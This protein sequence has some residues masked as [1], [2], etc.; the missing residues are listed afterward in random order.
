MTRMRWPLIVTL[1]LLVALTLSAIAAVVVKGLLSFVLTDASIHAGWLIVG[2]TLLVV[3]VG[4][5]I[6]RRRAGA[7][8]TES[9]RD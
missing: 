4:A 6:R 7:A 5:M 9:R 1:A 8:T 3:L 2:V